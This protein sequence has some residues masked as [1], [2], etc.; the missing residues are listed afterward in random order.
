MGGFLDVHDIHVYSIALEQWSFLFS[1]RLVIMESSLKLDRWLAESRTPPSCA[2]IH[3]LLSRQIFSFSYPFGPSSISSLPHYS[4]LQVG[5]T[6]TI[7]SVILLT[8]L[9]AL[10]NPP[11]LIASRR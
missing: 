8:L 5:P 9:Q 4:P 3:Q 6:S 2:K 7:A 10:A 11:G 1:E